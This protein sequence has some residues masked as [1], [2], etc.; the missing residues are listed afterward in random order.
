M[1]VVAS[2][3]E[4]QSLSMATRFKGSL[5]GL[6][7]TMG[8][9]HAGHRELIRLAREKADFTVVS[10]FVNPKQFGPNED[11]EKY[12]RDFEADRAVCEEEG[13]D[14][15]FCPTV[16]ELYPEQY[17]VYVEEVMVSKGLCGISRPHHF[18]GVTT[19]VAKLFNI[20]RPDVAVFGQKDAQQSAVLRK[21]VEDLHMPIEIVVGETVREDD[22]LALSSRNRYLT[23]EQRADARHIYE[24][25]L[26]GKELVDQ[27]NHSVDRIIAEVTH[28]LA[29]S[30]RIRVIY[31][32][33]VDRRYMQK[34]REVVPGESLIAVACWVDQ[35]RL[36]DNLKI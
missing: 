7:P 26:A 32:E 4:M 9:L 23:P 1:Q 25:L 20:V 13:V 28:T 3:H 6:V 30:R 12:P 2:I 16:A 19:V 27:G 34:M 14:L 33:V 5:I 36:I 22:G 17:S 35:T 18:K 31:A 21:M 15:V 8:A 29:R 11:F 10:L 24:A